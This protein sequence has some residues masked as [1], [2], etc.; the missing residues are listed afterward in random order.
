MA[1]NGYG[2]ALKDPL[3]EAI[4]PCKVVIT[5]THA[6]PRHR[7]GFPIV[8]PL[9]TLGARWSTRMRNDGMGASENPRKLKRKDKTHWQHKYP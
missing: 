7:R 5:S 6:L 3:V 1:L 8:K 2:W 9:K 4:I